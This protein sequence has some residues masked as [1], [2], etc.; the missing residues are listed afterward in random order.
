MNTEKLRLI[1]HSALSTW[2]T[3]RASYGI[4]KMCIE[5]G[6]EGDFVE[7]GVFAGS[8]AAA[9]ALA[10]MERPGSPRR[11]HLFDSFTGIPRA[12]KLDNDIRP[13]VGSPSRGDTGIESSGISACSR[14]DVEA[15]MR[16]WDIDPAILV[17]HEGWFQNTVPKAQ[18]GE[19]AILRLDG[20]LYDST[21][22]CLQHFY[23]RL[24]PGAWCIADDFALDGC[25]LAVK[26]EVGFGHPMYWRKEPS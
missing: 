14:R 24:S 17:Y 11:V 4:A 13:L 21:K 9:M 7:C 8:Q 25:R 12:G 22:I 5:Q 19:I 6:I 15:N 26:E 23:Q 18:I 20:D 3:V 2:G 16:R 1:G 10:I